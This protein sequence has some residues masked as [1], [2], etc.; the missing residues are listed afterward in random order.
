MTGDWSEDGEL[1]KIS[2]YSSTSG[3]SIA[4]RGFN[5]VKEK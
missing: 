1:G 4:A 3:A 5:D 2:L